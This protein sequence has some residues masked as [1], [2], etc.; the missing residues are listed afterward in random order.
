[1]SS[2]LDSSGIKTNGPTLTALD[3]ANYFLAGT[4]EAA[5]PDELISPL[6]LQ[7]LLYYA[8]GLY[9]ARTGEPLFSDEIQAWQHGPVVPSVWAHFK[10]NGSR[11]ITPPE[12]LELSRYTAEIREHLDDVWTV[13]GQFSAGKLRN[14][15]HKEEPWYETE[16]W[17]VITHEKMRRF[18]ESCLIRE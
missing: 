13:Y 11:G 9:L 6:K 5:D 14:M 18:F 2:K 4:D 10:D 12:S 1:M 16:S 15:T 7:K 17:A 8:Q 3:I